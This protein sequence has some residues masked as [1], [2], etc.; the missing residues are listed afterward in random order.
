MDFA[1]YIGLT[2]GILIPV[3]FIPQIVRVFRL[4]SAREISVLFTLIQLLGLALWLAYGVMLGLLPV[5][6][7][8]TVLTALVIML[9]GAKLKYGRER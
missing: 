3:S 9:L 4:R 8:N 1:S 7:C 2:A 6:V 5:V